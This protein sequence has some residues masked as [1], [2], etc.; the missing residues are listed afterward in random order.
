MICEIPLL[1]KHVKNFK[2]NDW[3]GC[4]VGVQILDGIQYA[5]VLSEN[6]LPMIIVDTPRR[7]LKAGNV[8]VT[9]PDCNYMRRS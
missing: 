4:Q 7:V 3:R 9:L 8:Y 5:D 1:P 2:L 6:K